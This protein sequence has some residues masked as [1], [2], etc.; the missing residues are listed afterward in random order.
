MSQRRNK[1]RRNHG[2]N[3]S[4]GASS[5]QEILPS[6]YHA[7]VQSQW[8]GYIAAGNLTSAGNFGNFIANSLLTPYGTGTY[9]FTQTTGTT[10]FL[11]VSTGGAATTANPIGYN[12]LS[13]N[14]NEYKVLDYEAELTV[15]PQNSGDTVAMALFPTGDQQVP[16]TGAWTYLRASAQPNARSGLAINGANN[17]L[18][19]VKIRGT[20]NRDVGYTRQQWLDINSTGVGS[21]PGGSGDPVDYLGVY[22]STLDGGTNASPVSVIVKMKQRVRM[23]D[24]VQFGN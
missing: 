8:S 9:P 14:Y 19:T 22:L 18:N 20:I 23:S 15:V 4:M 3:M 11:G 24:R 7:I 6:I 16:T 1:N 2:M 17:R 21:Q 5:G 10:P 12:F 13:S